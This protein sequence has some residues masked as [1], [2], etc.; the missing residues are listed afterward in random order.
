MKT[1]VKIITVAIIGASAYSVAG[2]CTIIC[3]PVG[4]GQ[5]C[6]EICSG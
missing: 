6:Q 5:V 4:D 2:S 1:L 3:T